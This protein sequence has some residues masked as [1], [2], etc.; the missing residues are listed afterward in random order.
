MR[1]TR[2]E[3]DLSALRSNFA[4][5]RALG[6]AGGL[7]CPMVKANA[8][9]HGAVEV[10]RVLRAA[11]ATVLGV[12]LFEEG[13]RLRDE[14]DRGGLLVFG[15]FDRPALDEALARDL[16]PV[17][18]SLDQLERLADHLSLGRPAQPPVGPVS[19]HLEFDT[20]MNR[21]GL[22]PTDAASARRLLD[23]TPLL[24]LDGVCT[25]LRSGEDLGH[26]GGESDAQM[27]TFTG[28][29]DVFRGRSFSVHVLNSAGLVNQPPN[30]PSVT[31]GCRPGISLYGAMPSFAPVMTLKSNL[32][33]FHRLDVNERV[34]YGGTWRAERRSLIGVLPVGYADGYFRA[35][36]NKGS[37]LVRGRLAPVAGR[38]CMDYL[39]L[40]LTE[41]EA[42]T[43]EIPLGEEAV[44]FGRQAPPAGPVRELRAEDVTGQIDTIPY[45]L[46]TAVSARVPR[47]YVD[48]LEKREPEWAT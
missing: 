12:A 6:P 14:G 8:Y 43:G 45:E 5:L 38:V 36:S 46:F 11:G 33:Q 48:R 41:I 26:P 3:I 7:M 47:V 39:M 31:L 40:D 20:G 4:S 19:I 2:A 28:V 27:A 16:T 42:A 18:G 24:R 17:V 10:S 29:V 34:S 21:L 37:A 23:R 13:I 1:S 30:Q 44:L 25:H 35:F 32:V 22:R 15:P 9:G